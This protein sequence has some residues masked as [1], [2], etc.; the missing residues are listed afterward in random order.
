MAGATIEI[1]GLKELIAKLGKLG[2]LL[3]ELAEPTRELL[4]LLKLRMQEYPPPPSGSKYVRTYNLKNS[5]QENVILA[6][7]V[8]GTV[9]SD[10]RYA[11]Y[12]Q[13]L[14]QQA[15]IHQGRWQ[16]MQSVTRDTEDEAVEIYESYL[17]ELIAAL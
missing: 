1:V 14:D 10:I 15:A 2:D 8:L 9:Q 12:V 6:G 4:E 17:K 3:G 13:D 11:P 7:S 5:W 16:T